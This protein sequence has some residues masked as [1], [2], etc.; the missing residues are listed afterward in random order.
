MLEIW[1]PFGHRPPGVSPAALAG[2]RP[3]RSTVLGLPLPAPPPGRRRGKRYGE[4]RPAGRAEAERETAAR[5]QAPAETTGADG[6]GTRLVGGV[7]LLGP[8]SSPSPFLEAVHEAETRWCEL[9]AQPDGVPADWVAAGAATVGL[10][11]QHRV[12]SLAVDR[13][14]RRRFRHFV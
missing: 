5:R 2:W 8:D 7:P 13:E 1:S 9:G 14:R 3:H 12:L 6:L 11:C 4:P 10:C